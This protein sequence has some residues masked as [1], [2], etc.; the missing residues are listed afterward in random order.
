M[1]L[2]NIH[3]TPMHNVLPIHSLKSKQKVR[4][5]T[6]T[7]MATTLTTD[8][9]L[10]IAHQTRFG[11]R[12]ASAISSDPESAATN[13]AFSPVSLHVALSLVAAGAR[14]ATR[15][16]LVAV[17]GGG[18]AGE[19]EALQS[20][21]E[22]VVQFVLADAS[23]NSG[24]RIAFAN[25]VFVDASL[26]LKPSFQEL[27]V[28]NYKSEVQSV[29]FKTK[30]PE[31]ASQVNSWV[32]NVTAGLIEEILPAGSID[33]TTRLVL[34]NAL[35]FKGLWTKKFDESKTKYDDFHLLNGSTVQT[36]F[37]S[38]TNK[39]YL[40]SSDGL[41]VLKLPYQHGGD[42]RQFSMYILLPEAHDGLSRLAQK[43]STEPDFLEN[44]I[45]T[46]EVEVGQFML[47]KFKTSFGFEANK[48][49]ETLGLQLPF[50]L[51]ANL[52]EMVNSPKG[53]YISSVFHKTFVEVDE[54]GTKAAAA[55]GDVIVERS[56]P[57]RMDFVANHPFLFLIRED[58][59]GVVLFIG[60]V[61]NPVVSS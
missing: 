20:L 37:M 6:T 18:G 15:D 9:R 61:A 23:I 27:A 24:P 49:L 34:G 30:A 5:T 59:A 53:L 3:P 42:N 11:L 51:E 50:S 10:S 60:H 54:E 17:L 21:A 58:I 38:S 35:Y 47:P 13:V 44:R 52:S 26:S 57:I 16:Q 29:D 25:G 22:Q 4:R 12:L 33:N 41:K 55:T 7:A 2:L 31:A 39:Q 46:K 1:H 40:S 48:L 14:G 45:P 19:A 32:K 36:P 8:L 28:C 56:L 43:L